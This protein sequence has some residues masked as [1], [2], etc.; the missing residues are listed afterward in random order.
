MFNE[1]IEL[2]PREKEEVI[3]ATVYQLVQQGCD[4]MYKLRNCPSEVLGIYF[5]PSSHSQN[6]LLVHCMKSKLQEAGKNNDPMMQATK[7]WAKEAR[8]QRNKR[9]GR[10]VESSEDEGSQ[11]FRLNDCLAKYNLEGITSEHMLKA[12]D[13]KQIAKDAKR[14]KE[15]RIAFFPDEDVLK[16]TPQWMSEQGYPPKSL[17]GKTMDHARWVACWWSRALSMLASQAYTEN[18]A[19]KFQDLLQ[20]FL[21]INKLA[22]EYASS[23]KVAWKYDRHIW[24]TLKQKAER[25]GKN[26]P[27]T[28][29]LTTIDTNEIAKIEKYIQIS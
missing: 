18:K 9:E 2:F 15:D 20:E 10:D 12:K 1:V 4:S 29:A 7:A 27:V 25:G 26:I 17:D 3:A 5:P 19:A 14:K 21:N 28:E 6:L 23:P 24:K 16:F 22:A 11:P 8:A 13:V